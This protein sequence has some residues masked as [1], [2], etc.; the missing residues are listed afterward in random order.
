MPRQIQP[1]LARACKQIDILD[2]EILLAHSL[3][4]PKEYI[5]AHP[6]KNVS[7]LQQLKFIYFVKKRHAGLPLSYITKHKEFFGL[8]FFV[9]KYTLVPRPDTEVLVDAVISQL[10]N[11]A[12]QIINYVLIDVG[13]GSGCIPISILKNIDVKNIRTFA[14]DISSGALKIAQKNA[15]S[16][17]VNIHF[18]HGN[19]FDPILSLNNKN[20][21]LSDH[22]IITA[23]LPYL[24]EEQYNSEKSIQHEPKS[25]LVAKKDGLK[26]YEQLL[27]QIAKMFKTYNLI[28]TTY[29]EIDPSQTQKIIALINK[30]MPEAKIII[31]KDLCGLDRVVKIQ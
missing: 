22:L 26:I 31:I 12:S 2:A 30:I 1:L 28:P 11:D 17:N 9:N 4:K 21:I 18:L 15:T 13:T 25:A 20:N 6:E 7:I 3:S 16:Y 27:Y 19:L 5:L 8:N 14:T 10:K 23:N 29:I 24:T